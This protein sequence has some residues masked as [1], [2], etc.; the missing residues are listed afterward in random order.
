[1]LHLFTILL[2]HPI[3]TLIVV[4]R[5][6]IINSHYFFSSSASQSSFLRITCG[7]PLCVKIEVRNHTLIFLILN[8][9][10]WIKKKTFGRGDSGAVLLP[11]GVGEL[12]LLI[13]LVGVEAV[14]LLIRYISPLH[15]HLTHLNHMIRIGAL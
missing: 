10:S 9:S 14:D 1:M 11:M 13:T 3:I 5:I 15:L 8:M 7:K 2:R 12:I 6:T 4:G